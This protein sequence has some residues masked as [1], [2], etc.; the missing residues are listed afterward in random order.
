MENKKVQGLIRLCF[1]AAL[2][3]VQSLYFVLSNI[4]QN[5]HNVN[6]FIDELIPFNRFFVVPYVFWY[7]YTVCVLVFFAFA[8]YK[9]Y[10]QLLSSIIAGMFVCFTIYYFFPT[11]VPRPGPEVL[12]NDVFSNLV[13]TI[14]ASD[15]PYNCFPSIHMMDTALTT[16]FFFRY[17]KNWVVRASTLVTAILIYLS[18]FFI[19]QHSVLDALS[20]TILAV[21]LYMVFTNESLWSRVP[22]GR[23]IPAKVKNDS[24]KFD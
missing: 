23:I 3:L 17:T 14:Y 16:M 20:A 2:P 22:L 12:G 13:R 6:T 9:I 7:F 15:K 1:I 18:T 4:T 10:F 8:N 5:A 24:I 21:V 11:T 19:K